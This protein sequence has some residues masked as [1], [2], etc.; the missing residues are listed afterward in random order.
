MLIVF[1]LL[2]GLQS[3]SAINFKCEYVK[4][5]WYVVG[6][7]INC[8]GKQVD[9]RVPQTEIES[10]N[11][12]DTSVD[13]SVKGFWIENEVT[14]YLPKNI[15]KFFPALTAFGVSKSGLKELTKF[16]LQPFPELK[17]IAFYGNQL[18]YL[19]A[20]VFMYNKKISSISLTDN[21]LFI[22]GHDIFEPLKELY[23]AQVE[24]RCQNTKC[25]SG[26][27]CFDNLT[28][29]LKKNCP[30]D[31]VISNFKR[32]IQR[33]ENELKK[34]QKVEITLLQNVQDCVPNFDV[35]ISKSAF[36]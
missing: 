27:S 20:D 36:T 8:Y 3:A 13:S 17:R 9:I 5:S 34:S 4:S 16:D 14:H 33:L 25:E 18:E 19:E 1:V 15:E 31:F 35:R 12:N 23:Y 22:I 32:E 6:D 26:R 24:I 11:D 21:N 30:S 10:I 2:F 7:I 29:D 28:R